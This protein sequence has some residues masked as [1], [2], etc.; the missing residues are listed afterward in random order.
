LFIFVII[1]PGVLLVCPLYLSVIHFKG[2]NL[3]LLVDIPILDG[4]KSPL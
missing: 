2:L 4:I 1:L 3:V